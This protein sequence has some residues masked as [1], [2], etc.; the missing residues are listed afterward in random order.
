M[1]ICNG[2]P[3]TG[4]NLLQKVCAALGKQDSEY[5]LVAQRKNSH[6][7]ARKI[8]D[9]GKVTEPLKNALSFN[10]D[11]FCHAHIAHNSKISEI[12]NQQILISMRDPRDAAVSF[13]RWAERRNKGW[14]ATK[15][16][17]LRLLKEGHFENTWVELIQNYVGW[18]SEPNALC[19]KFEDIYTTNGIEKISKFLNVNCD[20]SEIQPLI[21]GNG[22]N[23]GEGK[24]A[25]KS[26]SSFSGKKSNW[27]EWWDQDLEE[28]WRKTDGYQ[29]L[30]DLQE[31]L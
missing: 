24:Q 18:I 27:I 3:K 23:L 1:I 30:L 17:L 20:I 15:E 8:T 5:F 28:M 22:K 14:K 11:Y 4:T 9:S 31:I 16:D 13:V 7:T 10:N 19:I 6:V 29:L 12:K 25:Y 2:P 26:L 21:Y